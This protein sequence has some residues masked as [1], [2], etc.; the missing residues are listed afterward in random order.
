MELTK[1]NNSKIVQCKKFT[2]KKANLSE[3]TKPIIKKK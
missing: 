3:K 1:N 2:R